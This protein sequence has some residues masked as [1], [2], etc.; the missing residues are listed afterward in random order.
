MN[1]L[2]N[3]HAVINSLT[4][5]LFVLQT[6]FYLKIP[7]QRIV[8]VTSVS[9]SDGLL[10]LTNIRMTLTTPLARVRMKAGPKSRLNKLNETIHTQYCIYHRSDRAESREMGKSRDPESMRKKSP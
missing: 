9:K 5:A 10:G 4:T 3:M 8:Q 7:R 6:L 1:S 2:S